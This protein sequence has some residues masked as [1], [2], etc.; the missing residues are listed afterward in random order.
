MKPSPDDRLEEVPHDP[1]E[2]GWMNQKEGLQVLLV[3]PVQSL[4]RVP[5]PAQRGLVLRC[6]AVMEINLKLLG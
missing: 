2:V 6:K 3:T 4:V 5:K 1:D